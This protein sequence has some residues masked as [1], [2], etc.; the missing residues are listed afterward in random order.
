M[1]AIFFCG[2]LNLRHAAR[3][4]SAKSSPKRKFNWLRAPAVV[5]CCSATRRISLRRAGGN[6]TD[7]WPSSLAFRLGGP[8]EIRASATSIPSADVPDMRPRTSEG[9]EFISMLGKRISPQSAQR[10]QKRKRREAE[11][12]TRKK[13]T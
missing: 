1:R 9:L 10:T 6:L 13:V 5:E 7:V 3:A 11:K 2:I 4:A 8:P 12:I